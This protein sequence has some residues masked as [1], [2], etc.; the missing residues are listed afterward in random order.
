MFLESVISFLVL[1]QQLPG[2][3]TAYPTVNQQT[4]TVLFAFLRP[5]ITHTMAESSTSPFSGAATAPLKP[6][7]NR[8]QKQHKNLKGRKPDWNTCTSP[9]QPAFPPHFAGSFQQAQTP[10]A[11]HG[12]DRKA[13]YV[14]E[15]QRCYVMMATPDCSSGTRICCCTKYVEPKWLFGF[16]SFASILLWASRVG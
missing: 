16:F 3:F 8:H 12:Q 1:L 10:P 14:T 11:F 9:G 7:P 4:I 13:A 15:I 2:F 6:A 5:L